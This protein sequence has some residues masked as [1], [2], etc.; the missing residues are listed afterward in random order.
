MTQLISADSPPATRWSTKRDDTP[1]SRSRLRLSAW[2]GH[3]WE[4]HAAHALS[5]LRVR[6]WLFGV[7]GVAHEHQKSGV[8]EDVT[9]SSV[10]EGMTLT[11]RGREAACLG[12]EGRGRPG[13]RPRHQQSV[14]GA[15]VVN[16]VA[17]IFTLQDDRDMS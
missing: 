1:T 17:H 10:P 6:F 5:S 13:H 4:T 7:D 9:R 3:R 16:S 8:V 2:F 11:P 15:G 14:A 12:Y